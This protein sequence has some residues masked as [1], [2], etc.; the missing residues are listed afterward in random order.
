MVHRLQRRVPAGNKKYCYPLT[1][2][3]HASR[4]LLLCEAQE[5]TCEALALQPLS[6]CLKSAA[7]VNGKFERRIVQE[8]AYFVRRRGHN[9]L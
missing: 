6:A 9:Y 3:D 5:S 4:Y 8:I 7:A 1:V 2:T